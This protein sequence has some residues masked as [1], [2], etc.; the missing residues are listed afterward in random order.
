VVD[1]LQEIAGKLRELPDKQPGEWT[2]DWQ[3]FD[4]QR[5]SAEAAAKNGDYVGAIRGYGEAIRDIMRQ[6][7]EHRPTIDPGDGAI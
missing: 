2:V 1:A 6:L 5:D 3:P 7:R 4:A